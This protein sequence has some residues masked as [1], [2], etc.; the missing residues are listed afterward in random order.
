[1]PLSQVPTKAYNT[2]AESRYNTLFS[3]YRV[4]IGYKSQALYRILW[5]CQ[6]YRF[7]T[8][9]ACEH[10]RM[11]LPKNHCKVAAECRQSIRGKLVQYLYLHVE[12]STN[13]AVECSK[14]K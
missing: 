13:F 2:S 12:F 14:G 5:I 7:S 6:N 8:Q 10:P 3:M 9:S 11:S 1:M 4:C